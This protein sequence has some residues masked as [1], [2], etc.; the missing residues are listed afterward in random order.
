MNKFY[1]RTN[2]LDSIASSGRVKALKHLARSHGDLE[3]EVEPGA[4][5]SNWG[6]LKS[7]RSTMSAQDAYEAMRGIKDVD[8]IFVTK[9]V[10]PSE[11][12][13][14]YVIEKNLKN[15]KFNT[16]LNLIANEYITPRELSV[17]SNS[18]VYAPEEELPELMGKYRDVRFRSMSELS[19]RQANLKDHA[20]TL[21]GKITKSAGITP[22]AIGSLAAGALALRNRDRL[23]GYHKVYHGTSGSA[24]DSIQREG[25]DPNWGGKGGAAE[26][27][28]NTDMGSGFVNNSHNKVHYTKLRRVAQGYADT[29]DKDGGRVLTAYIPNSQWD[30]S[31]VD[32]DARWGMNTSKNVAA[33][34][35]DPITVQ[36]LKASA[37]DYSTKENL[38]DYYST[39]SGLARAATGVSIAAGG[40][41]AA[42]LAAKA[43]TKRFL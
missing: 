7:N 32:P 42:G 25:L 37:L 27:A 38:K 3:V 1:H 22:V 16:K 6:G 35:Y 28:Q 4:G 18:T 40:G 43:L 24:A 15:P 39:G 33:T 13:G 12:Y 14:K 8:N 17:R 36:N 19:A 29:V 26:T 2:N 34:T 21:F 30:E 20:K 31:E 10:L 11:S 9:D 23:L 41:L 5:G